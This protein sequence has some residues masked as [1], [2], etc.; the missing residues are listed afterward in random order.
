MREVAVSLKGRAA[1]H[2][3]VGV[4]PEGVCSGSGENVSG[5]FCEDHGAWPCPKCHALESPEEREGEGRDA[6][7]VSKPPI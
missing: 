6:L 4:G 1:R 3:R 5:I 7:R 2:N